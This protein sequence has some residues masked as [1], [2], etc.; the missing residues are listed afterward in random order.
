MSN[1]LLVLPSRPHLEHLKKQA[2]DLLSRARN[3]DAQA[4]S[5]CRAHLRRFSAT[6]GDPST[7]TL[8]EAQHV[9]A[10]GYSFA[11]WPELRNEV[12]QRR[13]RHLNEEGLPDD[14]EERLSLALAAV[15]QNDSHALRSLLAFDQSLAEGWGDRRPLALAA[16]CDFPAII[17]VLLDA[18]ASFEPDHSFPHH[19][20]SWSL[21]TQSL[22]AAQRLAERG[23]PVDFWCAAGLGDVAR[24][25]SFFDDHGQV[26]AGVSRYGA[27]RCDESGAPLPKPSDPIGVLSDA[28]Y[29]ACRAGQVAAA[30]VL[31]EHGADPA[32]RGYMGAP[33][34]HWAAF[35]GN[36]E[37]VRLLLDHGASATQTGGP[38]AADYREFAVR[39]PI[40]WGWL[41]ALKRVLAGDPSLVHEQRPN[42]G[43][44]LHAALERGLPE[45]VATLL[46]AG[47]DVQV[48][49]YAGRG[50]LQCAT[51]SEDMQV[52]ATLC[53]LLAQR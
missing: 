19:P 7:L 36:A 26:R 6:G 22:K 39:T 32:F 9:L 23:A 38:F 17:D 2:K 51:L 27:S 25:R 33:A 24:L 21:T 34:L 42:W 40:E 15:E 20:L 45:H 48:L 1:H 12:L 11:S 46:A 31:L 53:A 47:A 18:G 13:A 35:S 8:A 41:A 5:E 10:R 43:P 49:D 28:L 30:R 14:R 4:L 52:R 16:E 29:I 37:L 44:P 3:G 50:V